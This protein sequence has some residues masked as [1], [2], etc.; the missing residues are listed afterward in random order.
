MYTVFSMMDFIRGMD[1]SSPHPTPPTPTFFP[2]VM[3]FTSKSALTLSFT[4]F[5]YVQPQDSASNRFYQ[6]PDP[7]PPPP[8]PTLSF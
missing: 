5:K 8:P 2:N 6:A 4:F 3:V 7:C 1:R